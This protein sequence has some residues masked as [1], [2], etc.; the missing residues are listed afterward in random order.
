VALLHRLVVTLGLIE[1]SQTKVTYA[2]RHWRTK[3]QC[4]SDLT[5]YYWKNPA[6]LPAYLSSQVQALDPTTLTL[7]KP[8][9]NVLCTPPVGCIRV[10]TQLI[11]P[12]NVINPGP[13]VITLV[14]APSTAN[15][16]LQSKDDTPGILYED[17]WD[18]PVMKPFESFLNPKEPHCPVLAAS[19]GFSHFIASPLPQLYLED[20][21][22]IFFPSGQLICGTID[23]DQA[24]STYRHFH[25]PEICSPPLGLV[26]PTNIGFSKF[27]ESIQALGRA[28]KPFVFNMDT[29]KPQLQNWFVEAVPAHSERFSIPS[30]DYFLVEIAPAFLF[31]ADGAYPKGIFDPRGYSPLVDMRYAFLW[32][33]R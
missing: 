16:G 18:S 10:I 13:P 1:I 8:C 5:L 19:E 30:C 32:Y 17:L 24:G 20:V 22:P 26:W 12:P 7:M 14:T 9:I 25:L 23:N 31:I 4:K 21:R 27:K 3:T 2:G 33:F 29:I 15:I 6:N 28:Y 11:N